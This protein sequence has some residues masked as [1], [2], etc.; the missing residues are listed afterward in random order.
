[1]SAQQPLYQHS[2]KFTP[3]GLVMM[4]V[5]GGASA[6]VLGAVYGYAVAFNPFIYINFLATIIAGLAV[7]W[8]IG[9]AAKLGKV[10]NLLVCGLVGLVA[11]LAFEYVQWWATLRFFD[12]DPSLADPAQIWG[13]IMQ[14]AAFEPWALMG[15][16]SPG[17]VGFK[18][19]W[20]LE[21]VLIV[22][23]CA[24]MAAGAGSD[25]FC[26]RCESWTV[27]DQTIKPF[28]FISDPATLMARIERG[29]LEVLKAF[30]RVEVNQ[31]RYS[32]IELRTCPSCQGLRLA[33]VKNIEIEQ[34][35]DGTSKENDTNVVDHILLDEP[36][37]EVL[38]KL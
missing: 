38:T 32:A 14:L 25:P 18:A 19:I 35:K 13:Q 20:G 11:G 28:D 8:T 6:V 16:I 21:A 2:G 5:A 9:F 33:S 22:G 1:M 29:D 24:L 37:Y 10:R 15:G 30:E 34:E 26:E 7:G 17:P 23:A 31:Q 36:T 12:A 27:V 4:L 3:H